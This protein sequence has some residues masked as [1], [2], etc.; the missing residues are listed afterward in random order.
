[1][2]RRRHPTQP[3]SRAAQSPVATSST[4]YPYR[5]VD[6][7]TL[8]GPKSGGCVPDCRYVNTPGTAIL[9]SDTPNPDPFPNFCLNDCFATLGVAWQ[10]GRSTTLNPVAGGAQTFPAWI[11]DTDLVSGCSE[12]GLLDPATGVR[13]S[14]RRFGWEESQLVWGPWA[15]LPATHGLSTTGVKW[16]GALPTRHRTRWRAVSIV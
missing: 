7:G 16:S 8:G 14:L 4:T 6:L 3:V 13:K 5:A 15:E 10:N 9:R 2:H 11:S 12:N 1:M